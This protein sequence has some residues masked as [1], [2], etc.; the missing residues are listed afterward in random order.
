[1]PGYALEMSEL[2][3]A[4]RTALL[5]ETSIPLHNYLNDCRI[6]NGPWYSEPWSDYTVYL[7]PLGSPEEIVSNDGSFGVLKFTMHTVSVEC[8]MRIDNPYDE[9][10]VV[11]RT[12]ARIGITAFVSDV[13]SFLE[14]NLLGISSAKIEYGVPPTIEAGD[15]A[16][17]VVQADDIWLQSARLV[18]RART[19]PFERTGT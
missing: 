11:G 10:S 16:Y 7:S 19:R 1:M 12:G 5:A 17:V 9:D 8:C 3:V 14:N 18:Y 4:M 2:L 6:R 15:G 13:C